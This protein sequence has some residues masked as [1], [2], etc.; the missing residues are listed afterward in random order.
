MRKLRLVHSSD[1]FEPVLQ[2]LLEHARIVAPLPPAVQ[3][4][5]LAR[6]RAITV[7]S[8][9]CRPRSKDGRWCFDRERSRGRRSARSECLV[10]P[11]RARSCFEFFVG[12]WP[13]SAPTP[14]PRLLD[15]VL[16]RK[17]WLNRRGAAGHR[18]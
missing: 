9:A 1:F 18:V 12:W 2:T 11:I 4:R 7:R 6:A 17:E 16:A 15:D 5:A 10:E 13:R 14:T 8:S 3:A